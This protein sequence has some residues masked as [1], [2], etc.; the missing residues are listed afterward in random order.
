MP[1]DRF[2]NKTKGKKKAKKAKRPSAVGLDLGTTSIKAVELSFGTSPPTVESAVLQLHDTA[3][4]DSA[5][6]AKVVRQVLDRLQ[7]SAKKINVSISGQPVVARFVHMPR[8]S[9]DEISSAVRFEAQDRIPFEIDEVILDHQVLSQEGN[10][11]FVLLVAAKK[12]AVE[13]RLEVLRQAGLEVGVLDVD[14]FAVSNCFQQW[15]LNHEDWIAEGQEKST[16]LLNIGGRVTSINVLNGSTL[17]L[18]R[19]I[20]VGTEEILRLGRAALG[21]L[22]NETRMSLDYY[23]SQL[24]SRVD[25]I[26]LGGGG[27]HVTGTAEFIKE[28][29]GVPTDT[30][31]PLSGFE[32]VPR[33]AE[34][35]IEKIKHQL[36]VSLGLALR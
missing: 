29:L 21:K 31:D 28:Q 20:L 1:L 23:E 8:M 11:M 32:V 33:L 22:V 36:A 35:G 15:L 9:L 3:P 10:S 14:F 26:L 16:A 17:C 6:L 4:E 30:W 27:V 24:G 18:S 19:D 25:A 7:P 12:N 34:E 5:Q 13:Q 2:K